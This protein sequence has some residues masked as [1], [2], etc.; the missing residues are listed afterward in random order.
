MIKLRLLGFCGADDSVQP[1]HLAL[2][3][4]RYPWIEWGVLF[5]PDLEGQGRYAS[6]AWVE[7]LS[8]VNREHGN[9]MKLAA[10]LCAARCQ[11][12]LDGDASFARNLRR[13]GFGRIQ[14]NATAAN[15]VHVDAEKYDF[16]AKNILSCMTEVSDLEFIFQLNDETRGIWNAILAATSSSS[17]PKNCNVLFDASCGLGI[18][19]S[20]YPAPL[21]AGSIKIPCG[22]AG[23]IGPHNITEVI[24]AVGKAAG[25]E[26]VWV[27]MESSLRL[28]VTD[29]AN[30]TPRDVFSLEKCFDCVLKARPFFRS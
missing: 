24:A 22:Y 20:E 18:L 13:L 28:S 4:Q 15:K 11:Q 23:G 7:S 9:V 19:A 3:S 2:I 17:F 26:P 10:H 30:P 16:Y 27:D 8:R 29:K 21:T 12:V 25:E 5:R 1:E 6:E 14:I